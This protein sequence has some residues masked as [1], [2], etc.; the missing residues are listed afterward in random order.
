VGLDIQNWPKF[1]WFIVFH[2]SI[3]GAWSLWELSPPKL[4]V[5]TGLHP[6]P[7]LPFQKGRHLGMWFVGFFPWKH[8]WVHRVGVLEHQVRVL[9]IEQS[10]RLY[11]SSLVWWFTLVTSFRL[12][13]KNNHHRVPRTAVTLSCIDRT[14]V[15]K[16]LGTTALEYTFQTFMF[17]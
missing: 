8:C 11:C 4:P 17:R 1:H 6:P 5:E 10:Y 14:A 7:L 2:I 12:L 16:R 15:T 13:K 9:E 3:W